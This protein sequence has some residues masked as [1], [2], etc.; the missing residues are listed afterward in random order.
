[1]SL[2][3]LVAEVGQA[4]GDARG[5]FGPAP[6]AGEWAS[7]AGLGTGRDGVRQVIG[8][9][10][11]DWTGVG[12][13]TYV[14]TS[15]GQVQALDSVIGADQGTSPGFA[16]TADS[17]R[18]GRG[19]MDNVVSDTRT[20]VAALAPTTDTPAGR[21]Q[22]VNHLQGQLDRAKVLLLASERRN[23]ALAAMIRNAASGYRGPGA[24]MMPAMGASSPMMSPASMSGLGMPNLAGLT[25]LTWP[26]LTRRANALTHSTTPLDRQVTSGGPAAQEAVKAALSK[27]GRPYVWGAKGPNSFDCSGLT[28][29]AYAQAGVTL[30][31]DTYTQI[32]EGRRVAPGD[33]QAGDLI[34]PRDSFDGRGPGHVQLAISPTEVVHAPTSGDVVKIAGMPSAFAAVRPTAA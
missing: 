21:Q 29:W 13:S 17:S 9:A 7:T 28:R 1:M 25:N 4:L 33:V 24:S 14:R 2:D 6:E 23:V 32:T 8:A 34:F 27:L 15:S 18:G 11:R 16:A 31:P 19:R 10:A 30:G 5:L 22:L 12:A 26:N 3:A 20:G